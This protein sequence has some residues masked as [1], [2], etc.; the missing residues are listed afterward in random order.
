MEARTTQAHQLL[1]QRGQRQP[2]RRRGDRVV[3]SGPSLDHGQVDKQLIVR[4][5]VIVRRHRNAYRP[6]GSAV[7]A[8][9]TA[10]TWEGC[11]TD[12][13]AGTERSLVCALVRADEDESTTVPL[14]FK[15]L[16]CLEQVIGPELGVCSRPGGKGK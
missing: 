2:P 10:R 13:Q 12:R 9:V 7:R 5:G 16:A 1:K 3:T 8:A 4:P 11:A 15:T 14:S 6:T